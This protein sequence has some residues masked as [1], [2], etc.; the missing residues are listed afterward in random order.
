MRLAPVGNGGDLDGVEKTAASL[1]RKPLDEEI[2]VFGLTHMGKVRK[3]NQDHFLISFLR[4]RM[5]VR[6]TSLPNLS[7]LPLSEER[8]ATLLMVADGVGGG[9]RGEEASRHA[10]EFVTQYLLQSMHCY[11]TT[12]SRGEGFV[13]ALQEAALRAH[14]SVVQRGLNQPDLQGM[15]TTL[16]LFLIVWP[17]AYLLQ[18][19]DS[20]YYVYRDGMLSQVTRDQTL[21]QALLEEGVLT[22]ADVPRSPLSNVL[23]S[24][25][26]GPH[27]APVV[28]RVRMEW[29][30]VHVLCS[31]GLTKHVSDERIRERLA[32][33]TSAKQ[34]CETLVQDALEDGGSDNITLVVGRAVPA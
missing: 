16:T 10:L 17:W 28:T 11:Y 27:A 7:Q 13:N 15:A 29:P 31:D 32:A 5:E 20:R 33:M 22:R 3:V 24:A 9:P 2:D 26:G 12:D 23:S 8:M 6:L 34:A 18:V 4:K 30:M 21:A 1:T 14:E 25:I 19:G